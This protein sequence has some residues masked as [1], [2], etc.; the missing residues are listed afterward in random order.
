MARKKKE[1]K[2]DSAVAPWLVT[3]TDIM[4]L[5]LTFFVLIITFASF[6][7]PRKVKHVLGSITGTFGIGQ[8]KQDVLTR[9]DTDWVIEPGPMPEDRE[10][11]QLK[12]LLWEDVENDLNFVENKFV[13]IF[14]INADVLFG[15]GQATLTDEGE[16]LLDKVAPT[17]EN[18]E[19]PVL[20]AGH[21]SNLRDEYGLEFE[22]VKK[23]S[24]VDPSWPLSLHRVLSVY[25]Y[26]LDKDVD[27]DMIRVE[28]FGSFQPRYSNRTEQGRA[29]NRRVDII[30]DKRTSEWT[31]VQV[32]QE[33]LAD[34]EQE[35]EF[36]YRDFIFDVGPEQGR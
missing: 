21:T 35:N 8:A 34:P 5:L 31:R 3:F 1:K 4:T 32:N 7:D 19:H 25:R 29:D 28:A 6:L 15:P 33:A 20:L 36:I 12:P 24:P 13:Q 26:L 17:L 10:L 18:I 30:L 2:L 9:T 16:Q 22:N 11:Q 27:P 14:S 23:N